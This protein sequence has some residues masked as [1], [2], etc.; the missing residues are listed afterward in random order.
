VAGGARREGSRLMGDTSIEW[1][2]K[3]WN[4]VRGCTRVSPGCVNCYAEK[5]AARFS[6]AGLAYEGLA[7]LKVINHH[8]A[9]AEQRTR[10]EARWTGEVRMVPE[11]LADPL[12]WTKPRRIFVNSMSDLFHEKLSNEDIAAVFGVMAAAP[13]HTFQVLTKRAKRMRE[14]FAWVALDEEKRTKFNAFLNVVVEASKHL[15]PDA[16]EMGPVYEKRDAFTD[17]LIPERMMK[18]GARVPW[19][20]PNVWLGVSVEDQQ[21]AD[22]RIPE[23]LATPA[24]VRFVSYE[25]ALSAVNFEPYLFAKHTLTEEPGGIFQ[26]RRSRTLDWIIVGGESGPGARPFDVAW[27]RSVVQQ[28]K[29]AGVA[30]FVKQLGSRPVDETRNAGLAPGVASN[31]FN[32]RWQ[33]RSKKGGDMQEWPSDL[34]VREFPVRGDA[35]GG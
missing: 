4:P 29:A 2:Q 6:G 12:R 27:A 13:R 24:A 21:R 16:P 22:E 8:E 28:C 3:T 32:V 18:D 7:R 19:P 10:T 31:E 1:T 23:L 15:W 35:G 11:H 9:G 30:C 33:L 26:H 5:V 25:P 20:L 14:W 34:R 17:G